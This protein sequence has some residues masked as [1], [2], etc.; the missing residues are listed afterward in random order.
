[1]ISDRSIGALLSGQIDSSTI[2][3]LMQKNSLKKIKTF[4]I[5]FND[6][7][8]NEAK[9]ARLISKHLNTEHEELYIN[10]KDALSMV[11]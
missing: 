1:M 11:K 5:G 9:Y 7:K 10:E 4:S 6:K 3:A 2:A 8:F